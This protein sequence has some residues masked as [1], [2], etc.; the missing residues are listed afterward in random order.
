M[1]I[2]EISISVCSPKN[3]FFNGKLVVIG[4]VPFKYSLEPVSKSRCFIITQI[5]DEPL[6]TSFKNILS[7]YATVKKGVKVVLTSING[8]RTA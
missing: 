2:A 6:F 7:L 8:V 4:R 3:L 1:D 5:E